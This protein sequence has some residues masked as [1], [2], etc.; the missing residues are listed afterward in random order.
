VDSAETEDLAVETEHARHSHTAELTAPERF[1]DE[2]PPLENLASSIGNRGFGQLVARMQDGEGIL[3]GGLVHPDVTRAIAAAKGAGR[4]L[5]RHVS[6]TL[7]SGI[8]DSLGDVRVHTGDGAEALA[9]AVSARAFT[10]GSDIFFG[11]GEYQPQTRAGNELIAH[12]VAHVVQQRG[13]PA[14]GPLTVSQPGDAM[15]REAESVARDLTA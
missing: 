4:P 13:A 10:V 3:E 5:D 1:R 15:E 8:G 14:S 9:R 12:E 6:S 11:K 7:S 2:R